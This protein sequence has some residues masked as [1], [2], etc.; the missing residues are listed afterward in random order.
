MLQKDLRVMLLTTLTSEE[1]TISPSNTA[2]MRDEVHQLRIT[3][4]TIIRSQLFELNDTVIP[5]ECE[6]KPNPQGDV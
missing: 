4:D 6:S 1:T 5:I 2:Q 3:L